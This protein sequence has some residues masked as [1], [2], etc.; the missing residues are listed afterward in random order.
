MS[1]AVANQPR[2][3]NADVARYHDEGYLIVRDVFDA[4][5]IGALAAECDTLVARA[6][7][8]DKQNIR[9]RWSDH[10]ETKECRFDCFDPV[11]DI[12]PVSRYFAYDDR[13]L[14]ILRAI[15]DDEAHL[16]KDKLI[17]KPPGAKGYDLHQDYIGW[18]SF[19]ESFITVII[20]ID[21]TD[22]GNGAT[23]VY[24]GYHQN[25]CLSPRDGN[26]HQ[27]ADDVVDESRKVVL[28]LAPGD[29]AM[30]GGF[31]PHRSAPNRSPH[32][33]RQLYV[34]YNAGRDGGDQRDVHYR[35]FHEWLVKKYAEYGKH[36]VWF[37]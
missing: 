23:S 12:G 7:L 35:E 28:D 13:I 25:G 31:T 22:A 29:I 10:Y 30:F 24:T 2:V 20:A 11:I 16:V 14:S 5:E 36:G 26:Y 17:F 8:I 9:C 27:L 33:R 3:S 18:T 21:P 6:E 34:S 4:E 19:P 32:W 15:Y 37:R 1:T